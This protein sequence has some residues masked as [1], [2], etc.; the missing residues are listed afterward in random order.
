MSR[1]RDCNVQLLNKLIKGSGKTGRT[2]SEDITSTTGVN[3]SPT[4]I[5]RLSSGKYDFVVKEEKR[6][7]ICEY[8]NVSEGVLFPL[9]ATSGLNVS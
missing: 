6:I 1:Y 7:A 3:I 4:L 2:L 9:G 8:F 5:W